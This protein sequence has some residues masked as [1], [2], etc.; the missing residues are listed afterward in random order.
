M[1]G[2]AGCSGGG[3][4]EPARVFIDPNSVTLERGQT[5]SFNAE[6]MGMPPAK[7]AWS[8]VEGERGGFLVE[9]QE[10]YTT[11]FGATYTAPQTPG[12]YHI[13]VTASYEMSGTV[14]ATATVVV[15]P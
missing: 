9:V 10:G 13:R 14:T 3:G 11:P 8:V 7:L 12:T 4:G 15:Q 6:S 5:Q 1:F 2:L